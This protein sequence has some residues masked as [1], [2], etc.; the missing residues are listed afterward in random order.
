MEPTERFSELI[1]LPE[2]DVPLDE[3]ALLIAAHDHPVDIDRELARIADLADDAPS[4]ATA[5]ATYLFDELGFMGNAADY[6]DARNSYL[7]EVVRRRLGLPI[8]LSVLMLEV[9]RRTGL[10][11]VGIG[12]PGHFL[13]GVE[14]EPD[15]F[16]DPFHGGASLD[17]DQC[18]ALFAGVQ[19]NA[20]FEPR[21]LEP[22][23]TYA[24]V[25]RMLANLVHTFMSPPLDASGAVWALRLRLRVPGLELTARRQAARLLGTL[26]QFKEGAEA[27][28]QLA[29]Q[30]NGDTAAR[31]ARSAA[32]LRAREN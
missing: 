2:S 5:L 11:L 19:P 1:A 25:G 8:T 3:A 10:R 4:D 31:D 17:A 28:E 26:G 30:I 32:A 12:M 13:V 22:T 15:V 18:Q 24:I 21:H 14:G 7:D 23:G 6:G 9:G 16:F 27:L 20:T 29:E